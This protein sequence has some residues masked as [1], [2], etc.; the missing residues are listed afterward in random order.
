MQVTTEGSKRVIYCVTL[1]TDDDTVVSTTKHFPVKK[2]PIAEQLRE[3][4]QAMTTALKGKVIAAAVLREA[5]F[6]RLQRLTDPNKTR[7]RFEGVCLAAADN[8]SAAVSVMDGSDIGKA[9]GSTKDD[10]ISAGRLV[11][12]DALM[13]EAAAAAIAA[14]SLLAT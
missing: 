7:L 8:V 10:A 12:D 5:D 1:E 11:V 9:C 2:Q 6:H 14:K 4:H 13:A 3:A